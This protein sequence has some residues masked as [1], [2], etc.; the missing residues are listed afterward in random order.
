MNHQ[1]HAALRITTGLTLALLAAIGASAAAQRPKSTPRFTPSSPTVSPYLGLL[2][3]Q[4]GALPNYFALVRPLQRQADLNRQQSLV[5]ERQAGELQ[6]QAGEIERARTEFGQAEARPTGNAA[7]FNNLP[8][9]GAF[10]N[11]SHFFGQWDSRR[12][13]PQ[14]VATGPGR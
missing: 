10:R 2:S 8:E 13:L 4:G 3:N 7:W 9:G 5:I 1:R 6:R 12:G 11:R 14:R